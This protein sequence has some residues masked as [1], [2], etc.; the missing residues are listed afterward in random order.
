MGHEKIKRPKNFSKLKPLEN[1]QAAVVAGW[2]FKIGAATSKKYTGFLDYTQRKSAINIKPDQISEANLKPQQRF[3]RF[4]DYTQRATATRVSDQNANATFN[5]QADFL[6]PNKEKK[7]RQNLNSAQRNGSPLWQGY[8]SFSTQWLAENNIYDRKTGEVNQNL[9]RQAVRRGM[10]QLLTRE[11]FGKSAFWWGNIQFDTN[12]IHVHLGLAETKSTRSVQAGQ[13]RGRLEQKS[14]EQFKSVVT[15]QIEQVGQSQTLAEQK[16]LQKVIG[17][18]KKTILNQ[19]ELSAAQLHAIEQ[20]LPVDQKKWTTRF[21]NTPQMTAAVIVTREYIHQALKQLPEYHEWRSL[22]EKEAQANQKRYGT[23]SQNSAEHKEAALV[24]QLENQVWRELKEQPHEAKKLSVAMIS[25]QFDQAA[26]DANSQAIDALRQRLDDPAAQL[27]ETQKKQMRGDL[28]IRKIA[29]KQ[30]QIKY[31]QADHVQL[32]TRLHEFDHQ[33]LSVGDN[34]FLTQ[35]AVRLAHEIDH[36]QTGHGNSLSFTDVI[37]V[38]VGKVTPVMQATIRSQLKQEM[39][40]LNQADNVQLIHLVYPHQKNK[41]QVKQ[42]LHD[43]AQIIEIKGEINVNQREMD[44]SKPKQLA[45]LKQQNKVLYQ[46]LNGLINPTKQKRAMQPM[47]AQN[48]Y[49]QS[50]R[51]A[52]RN[53][54]KQLNQDVLYSAKRSM[55]LDETNK[56]E[57]SR[58]AKQHEALV[59]EVESEAQRPEISR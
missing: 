34:Y 17:K 36:L 13:R 43:Q 9:L 31:Q 47:T 37:N 29:R 49:R 54:R 41:A 4:I 26:R 35:H 16:T 20:A 19:V 48:L 58:A 42:W 25:A 21:A 30:Q 14:M 59:Q 23:H 45:S 10:R 22:I 39:K 46:R 50:R 38:Q 24:K 12:H 33:E 11:K 40:W 15:H 6:T 18:R 1:N 44:N 57:A 56:R 51:F 52:S 3:D 55:S 2:K 5:Q 7:L 32:L 8:V 27:T 53:Q 28:I